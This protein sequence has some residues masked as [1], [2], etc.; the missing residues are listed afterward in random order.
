MT[1]PLSAPGEAW[2]KR[3]EVANPKLQGATRGESPT[4]DDGDRHAGSESCVTVKQLTGDRGHE[5]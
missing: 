5:A 2:L 1:A 4:G 3:K